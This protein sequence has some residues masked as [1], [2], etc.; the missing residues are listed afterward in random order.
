MPRKPRSS[1]T[2]NAQTR[3]SDAR[4]MPQAV[5]ESIFYID[6]KKWRTGYTYAW[7]GVE[8]MNQPMQTNWEMKYRKGWRPVPRDRHPDLFPPMPD[9]GFANGNDTIV[10]R[11]GQILC[12]RPTA[13]VENDRRILNDKAVT[14]MNSINWSQSHDANP[15]I[16]RVNHSSPVQFGHAASF[17]E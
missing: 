4:E 8:C 1:E 6:P 12:E 7:V 14:Q 15:L 3:A 10:R 9:I 16:P 5:H 17:K 11:G 2:R 13:D